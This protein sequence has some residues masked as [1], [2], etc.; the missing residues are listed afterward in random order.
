[1]HERAVLIE[2]QM[3]PPPAY[4][5][6]LA[7]GTSCLLEAHEHYQKQTHRNRYTINTARGP[8][9]LTVPVLL[10]ATPA[11]IR[12]VRT[13]AGNRWRN[14]HWRTLE[15]AYRKAPFFEYYADD[16]RAILYD[17]DINFLWDLNRRLL[18]FCLTHFNIG[19]HVSETMAYSRT[20]PPDILDLRGRLSGRNR[21]AADAFYQPQPYQQVFGSTFVPNCSALDLLFCTGPQAPHCLHL[22]LRPMNK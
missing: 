13:E 21:A 18:S 7:Q 14:Q 4:F 11:P 17:R 19:L 12:A 5:C 6:A 15:A 10:P 2:L 20:P 3:L 22:S 1:M 9:R 16:L 8:L